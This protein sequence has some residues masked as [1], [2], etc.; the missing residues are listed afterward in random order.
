MWLRP[1][2]ELRFCDDIDA[3]VASSGSFLSSFLT[4]QVEEE[5]SASW[6]FGAN[7]NK[8]PS[9]TSSS[10]YTQAAGIGNQVPYVAETPRIRHPSF[11][12]M[13]GKHPKSTNETNPNIYS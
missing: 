4:T 11:T 10:K 9:T 1:L 5:G 3:A 8:S 13:N 2:D 12:Y 7:I 6:L